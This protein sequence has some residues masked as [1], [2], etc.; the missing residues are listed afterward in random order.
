MAKASDPESASDRQ[1]LPTCHSSELRIKIP[2]ITI[3]L[4]KK[5]EIENLAPENNAF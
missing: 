5:F 1:K 4:K 3:K 2:V